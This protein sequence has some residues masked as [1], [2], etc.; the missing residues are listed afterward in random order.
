[1]KDFPRLVDNILSLSGLRFVNMVVPILLIPYLIKTLGIEGFGIIALC[2]AVVSYGVIFV[3]YGFNFT[4]TKNIAQ[5]D[6]SSVQLSSA[7]SR[8]LACK[9]VLL[10]LF[11]V[12][13]YVIFVTNNLLINYVLVYLIFMLQ[14]IGQTLMP[15]F[16]F[17]GMQNIRFIAIVT[18]LIK[19]ASM[20]LILLFVKG[21]NDL[22]LVA[23]FFSLGFLISG[24]LSLIYA[25]KLYQLVFLRPSLLDL[26][27]EFSDGFDVFLGSIATTSYTTLVPVILSFH[28]SASDIGV[29]STVEKLV[30]GIKGLL[31]PFS[32]AIFPAIAGTLRNDFP[33]AIGLINLVRNLFIVFYTFLSLIVL[34]FINDISY[35]L[36]GG[37]DPSLIL[38]IKIM[39]LVPIFVL[40]SNLYGVQYMINIGLDRSF[41]NI[42]LCASS[43]ALIAGFFVIQF[44]GIIGAGFLIVVTELVIAIAMFSFYVISRSAK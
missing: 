12:F 16:L 42:I 23:T 32:Q 4:A 7:V 13:A 11:F 22:V 38:L 37:I 33:K 26:K 24:S 1:M 17:Q 41:R 43:L 8:V 20:L 28:V 6:G 27:R 10:I 14:V 9:A 40:I 21:K 36:V 34:F 35:L 15:T 44:F 29:F 18:G 30:N 2:Q 3:D 39:L 5:S 25:Q 19:L 31:V